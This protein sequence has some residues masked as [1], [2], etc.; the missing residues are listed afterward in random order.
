MNIVSPVRFGVGIVFLVV[1]IVLAVRWRRDQGLSPQRQ[2]AGL[3]LIGC[4]AFIAGGLG[5]SL[6]G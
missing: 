1:A 3:S 2:L 6:W 5:H 4:V